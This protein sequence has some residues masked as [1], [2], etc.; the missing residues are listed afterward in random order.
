M[1]TDPGDDDDTGADPDDGWEDG[2]DA[3]LDEQT[4]IETEGD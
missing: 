4:A 2:G 3:T 1:C